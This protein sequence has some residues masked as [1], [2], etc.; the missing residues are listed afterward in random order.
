ML[1]ISPGSHSATTSNG[2]QQT[3]Q[4]VVKRWLGRDVSSTRSNCAPQNGHW[5]V[6]V[7]SIKR[8]ETLTRRQ[9]KVE[10]AP[11]PRKC[12]ANFDTDIG[13]AS[14]PWLTLRSPRL[15]PKAGG[16]FKMYP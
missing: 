6:A 7:H 2:R 1:T 15:L 13:S 12:R 10:M 14:R 11:Q 5:T 4:S 8:K 16:S 9:F 3:S